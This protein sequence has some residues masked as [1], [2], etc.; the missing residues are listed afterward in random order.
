VRKEREKNRNKVNLFGFSIQYF[1]FLNV[2]NSVTDINPYTLPASL[3]DVLLNSQRH[4]I[5]S[6]I[7]KPQLFHFIATIK[8]FQNF[9]VCADKN[10]DV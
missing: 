10:T 3:F 6:F 1:L 7:L 4:T 8:G 2:V 5:L 9:A